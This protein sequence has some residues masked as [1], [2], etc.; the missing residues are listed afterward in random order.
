M[1]P[2]RQ[3]H[4]DT[5]YP[6]AVHGHSTGARAHSSAQRVAQKAAA[7]AA[8]KSG[9]VIYRIRLGLRFLSFL[10][11]AA[12][13]G[14]LAQSLYSYAWTEKNPDTERHFIAIRLWAEQYTIQPMHLLLGAACAS[15]LLSGILCIASVSKAVG[16]QIN[17]LF[18]LLLMT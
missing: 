11:S 3:A 16:S 7:Q 1:E 5:S 8:S 9:K 4:I 13:V 14:V 15:T 10:V 6:G 18:D 12:M 17:L 2:T